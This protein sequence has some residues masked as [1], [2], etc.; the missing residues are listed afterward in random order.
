MIEN[1][2]QNR[3]VDGAV[4]VC[5]THIYNFQCHAIFAQNIWLDQCLGFCQRQTKY[6]DERKKVSYKS[7]CDSHFIY[8]GSFVLVFS[9]FTILSVCLFYNFFFLLS[10]CVLECLVSL[11]VTVFICTGELVNSY[12]FSCFSYFCLKRVISATA[13]AVVFFL[14]F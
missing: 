1:E 3:F 12:K 11:S 5:H 6:D 4:F 10:L 2:I 9:S 8:C 13:A 7:V 14:F